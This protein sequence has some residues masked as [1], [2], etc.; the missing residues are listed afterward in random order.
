MGDTTD[1]PQRLMTQA[2]AYSSTRTQTA[3]RLVERLY[4]NLSSQKSFASQVHAAAQAEDKAALTQ[5]I[6]S[7]LKI[8]PAQV[9]IDEV[10][11]D[12]L[13][14]GTVTLAG[15]T[16]VSYC[17][18]TEKPKRGHKPRCGGHGFSIT[19]SGE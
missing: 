7:N 6:A 4:K 9:I 19:V 15:G 10:D 17:I 13:I 5:L 8:K 11:K 3:L 16:T 14:R 1:T 12:I 18:D 2:K